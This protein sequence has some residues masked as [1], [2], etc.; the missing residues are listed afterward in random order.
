ML[1]I[2][3]NALLLLAC[4]ATVPLAGCA[5]GRGSSKSDT[6]YVARDVSTLYSTAKRTMDSGDYET[7]AKLFDEVE[8]QH[9]YSV[10]ARRAQLMSAFNYYL[11]NKY[12]DAI[13]SARRF[14]TIHPGNAEAP[15]AQ[16]LIAMSYYQ[17]IPDVN[18]DQSTTASAQQA[19]SELIRRYP[20]SRYAADARL[21][22]DLITDH[23]AGK[24]MEVG[25][26]YQRSGQWLAATYRFREVVDKYQTS[27][28]TPEALE[29]LVECYLAL[30]IPDEARKAGAV[31][32]A[33]Y[34]GSY[35]YKQSLKL[36]NEEQRHIA[37]RTASRK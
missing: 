16:Y 15:Y 12:S 28:H 34:N 22:L 13:N 4:A 6:Q 14:V 36:L 27:S 17:Q 24:A 21:K 2:S 35:W 8:R 18:R 19:F 30:G 20:E 5:H 7:A 1:K 23:L 25:R 11:S 37:P 26:F 31:L 33:N 3:R 32:G 9:P 10:W 29:R